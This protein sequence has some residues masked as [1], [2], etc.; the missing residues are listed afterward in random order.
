MKNFN[1]KGFT[2][3]ELMIAFSLTMV[4]VVLLFQIV[5][6]LKDIYVSSGI[7]TEIFTKNS[8]FIRF[9]Q[10][11][12]HNKSLV[13]FTSCGTQCYQFGYSDGSNIQLSTNIA[14]R[15]I[16]YGKHTIQLVD[17]SVMNSMYVDVYTDSTAL[18]GL[19]DTIVSVIIPIKN[20]LFP[21]ENYNINI[22]FQNDTRSGFVVNV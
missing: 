9:V 2:I 19:D 8:N 7:K 17:G 4:V 16:S 14:Q 18:E 13:S 21:T 20:K 1:N 6:T 3:V 15:T 22:V 10:N 5:L 12:L 11:D